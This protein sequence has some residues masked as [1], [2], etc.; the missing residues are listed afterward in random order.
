MLVRVEVIK[1]SSWI[2][3]RDV[4]GSELLGDKARAYNVGEKLEFDAS[5]Q[6]YI[7]IRLGRALNV[8]VFINDQEVPMNLEKVTQ[9]LIIKKGVAAQ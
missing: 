2:G 3:I 6:E 4:N 8:K 5:S 9:N 1:E 7:R